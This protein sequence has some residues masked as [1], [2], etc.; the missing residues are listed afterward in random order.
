MTLVTGRGGPRWGLLAAVVFVFGVCVFVRRCH[1]CC[2]VV[3]VFYPVGCLCF[4][5]G[6]CLCCAGVVVVVV[7][8][9]VVGGCGGCCP[10]P[11]LC[12]L[13]RVLAGWLPGVFCLWFLCC[14]LCGL[15]CLS[16]L[17]LACACV[18]SPVVADFCTES[19]VALSAYDS[20]VVECVCSTVCV[21]LYVVGF[22]TVGLLAAFVVEPCAADWAVGLVVVL[23]LLYGLLSRAFPVCCCCPVG[24][25]AVC[26]P[27]CVGLLGWT[28][29]LLVVVCLWGVWWVLVW[30]WV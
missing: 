20:D 9:L 23:C 22:W 4:V 21:W 8:L 7:C 16:C 3:F 10:P 24:W 14:V 6:V 29:G 17:G 26:A 5:P 27:L 13:V 15:P 25:H 12:G 11:T 2:R 1:A 19:L 18:P 28:V 30:G